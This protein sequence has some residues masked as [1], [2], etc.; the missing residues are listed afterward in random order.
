MAATTSTAANK[1]KA[2]KLRTIQPRLAWGGRPFGLYNSNLL[3]INDHE[4][5]L[6]SGTGFTYV[7]NASVHTRKS[8]IVEPHTSDLIRIV[9]AAVS[10]EGKY[11]GAVAKM[12]ADDRQTFTIVVYNTSN[13]MQD[14]VKPHE[15]KYTTALHI[16]PAD[17][18]EAVAITFSPDAN[19][20][21]ILTNMPPIGVIIFDHFRGGVFQTISTD[22]VPIS[23]SFNPADPFKICVTGESNF[24][25][26]WRFSG[27]SVH[28][29]PVSGLKKGYYSYTCHAWTP[30]YA[31]SLVVIGSDGGFLS[32]IQN[33]EQRSP[34]VQVFG[35][36]DSYE[37]KFAIAHI[38]VR[39]DVVV[40]ASVCN[41]IAV[42]EVRR[43]LVNKGLPGLTA[44]L[45]PLA[46]YRLDGVQNIYGLQFCI[47]ESNTSYTL[48]AATSNTLAFLDMITDF[49]L[50][51]GNKNKGN[52]SGMVQTRTIEEDE[53][54][55]NWTVISIDKPLFH[56]H[57]Q[58]INCLSVAQQGCSFITF[59]YEEAMIR[60]WDY[61]N[62]NT[63]TSAW[64]TENFREKLDDNPFHVDLH[65][66]GLML[67]CASETEVKEF[68]I[69][70]TQ[71]E[72]I[73]R[74]PVRV[75][76]KGTGG[77]PI[78]ITQPVSLVK[79]S[80][81]GHMLA[82]VTGKIAQIFHMF[83]KE[84]HQSSTY[85]S[86]YRVMTLTDHVAPITDL[87]FLRD[88]SGL[89]TSSNDGS[90]YSWII[91]AKTRD[92]EF[93]RKGYAVT[94]LTVGK[95]QGCKTIIA[96]FESIT[97]G[98][99]STLPL[100]TD[101]VRRRRQSSIAI[102]RSAK[103]QNDRTQSR[104]A[105]LLSMR[106]SRNGGGS[107][108]RG[109]GA[110]GGTGGS[111]D[112][113]KVLAAFS[114]AL[115]VNS[116]PRSAEGGNNKPFSANPSGEQSPVNPYRPPMNS[117]FPQNTT[118]PNA[119]NVV[120]QCFL[121]IW[122]GEISGSPTVVHM[123]ACVKSIALGRSSGPDSFELCII[124]LADGQVILSMLPI[125]L[126]TIYESPGTAPKVNFS[127]SMPSDNRRA[128]RGGVTK[129]SV[130]GALAAVSESEDDATVHSKPRSPFA[131]EPEADDASRVSTARSN[132]PEDFRSRANSVVPGSTPVIE[133]TTI[134][135]TATSSLEEAGVGGT[136]HINIKECRAIRVL[137][138]GVNQINFSPDGAW[139]ILTGEDGSVFM[140]STVRKF[141]EN[142]LAV[143][144]MDNQQRNELNKMQFLMVERTKMEGVR[145]KLIE[146]ESTLEQSNKDHELY[147]NKILEGREKLM[148]DLESKMKRE[149]ISRDETILQGRRDY[150]QLKKST[151][152]EIESLKKNCE[153]SLAA[154]EMM[155]ERRLAQESVYLDKMRQAYDEY[156]VN[157]KMD[158]VS[159]Q[160]QV[161]VK[162]HH[163]ES[164]KMKVLSEAERQK[165]AILQYY[166]YI[167][168][169]NEEVIASLEDQQ[170]EERS[171][172]KM[173]L[174]QTNAMLA[175]AQAKNMSSEVAA[176]HTIQKL[177]VEID[178]KEMEVLH[179]NSDL[180]WANERISKLEGALQQA[181]AELRA[182]AEL[183][184][185]WEMRSGEMSKRIDDLE[186]VRKTLTTQLHALREELAPK[187][188][189]LHKA[190]E[191]MQEMNREYEISL[192][193]I[194]EKE[195]TLAYKSENLLLLQKQVRDL[196]KVTSQKDAA[197]RRSAVLLEEFI[198]A[199]HEERFMPKAKLTADAA[200]NGAIAAAAVGANLA[201]NAPAADG[202]TRASMVVQPSANNVMASAMAN[203]AMAVLG[204]I[205]EKKANAMANDA[206]KGEGGNTA[207]TLPLSNPHTHDLIAA[208]KLEVG[209]NTKLRRL[210][211]VLKPYLKEGDVDV[212]P[213]RLLCLYFT[214]CVCY[215]L[216]S[217]MKWRQSAASKTVT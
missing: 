60:F 175:E 142:P 132:P 216:K 77:A 8:Y 57:S 153:E 113:G 78:V 162:V 83:L 24:V 9:C 164:E 188:D 117:G 171:K 84:E 118:N 111:Q 93:I 149:V 44:T 67:S 41:L 102:R 115:D 17:R 184:D 128:V 32:C 116:P 39:G 90:V 103:A 165:H 47:R 200:L 198:Y 69:W 29:A 81:G 180:E 121:A 49:D 174:S 144:N 119:A 58:P 191:K 97:T 134:A 211:D 212:S 82:V 161:E 12:K 75:P 72:L 150:L 182:R 48:M 34:A 193:A 21:G 99:E 130:T 14:N 15:V 89:I 52:T 79:Y 38:L 46:N 129:R 151:Q 133:T 114:S 22:A 18:L 166:E 59:S 213:P 91:G 155:Y 126:I 120:K 5:I 65:P 173:S 138:G 4:F 50:S 6:S 131:V 101:I 105:G 206:D 190:A 123:P 192:H 2:L 56:F 30:P 208:L 140:L 143:V 196:R 195:K 189:Q 167:K 13:H 122:D 205:P 158:M 217:S 187:E 88:D 92:K 157:M 35:Q 80:N 154:L 76:F 139:I 148:L 197:L 51:G 183:A 215:R 36:A 95:H 37:T 146:M 210:N 42:Y 66:S 147:V 74:I 169:R 107:S 86:P 3:G 10:K 186:K 202:K 172:L 100:A 71:I 62:P 54:V 73:R 204:T 28:A 43:A 199:M 104:D 214:D 207:R 125:P 64:L 70:D 85:G 170:A 53:E 181:T 145:T 109:S 106:S 160:D 55:D 136:Y 179:V 152:D 61:A 16:D 27:K 201:A 108:T 96:S 23:I 20:I 40:A 141:A 163:I 33:C 135:M 124:G 25:K 185:K 11:V 110:E 176:S 19:L 137:V 209:V 168:K 87:V 127:S 98:T 112:L 156:V 68:A 177:K 194:T 26:L 1:T 7:E 159:I 45:T 31:E 63:F 94:H 178:S 203:A